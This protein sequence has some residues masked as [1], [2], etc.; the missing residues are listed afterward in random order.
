MSQFLS[1]AIDGVPFG[2]VYALMAIG[3]VLTYQTSGV[4]N[5][6]FGAQAY[7]AALVFYEGVATGWPKWLAF[8]VAVLIVSPGLGVAMDRLLFRHIRT[9]PVLVKL[10][11]ALGMLVAIP[12]VIQLCFGNGAYPNPPDVLLSPTTVYFHLAGDPINGTQLSTVVVTAMAVLL[13]ALMFHFTQVGLR[14]RAMAESPR[15]VQLTGVNAERMGGVTWALSSTLAGLAGVL[16]AP[17]LGVVQSIDFTDLLVAGMAA[18][19]VGSLTSLPLTF[20][21]GIGLGLAE[22]ILGG[23]LPS[24]S[25]LSSGLTFAFPFI[26]LLVLLLFV[27]GL[28][29]RWDSGSDPL[30]G[31]DPPPP[32][33]ASALR[34][35]GLE[36]FMYWGLRVLI[37]VFFL[38]V[39]TWVP[40]SWVFVFIQGLAFSIIFLSITL[41]TGM[42]GQISLCQMAFAGA[43]AFTAGQLAMHLNVSLLA[44]I[45]IGG[46]VAAVLGALV[47]LPAL[48][49]GGLALAIATL[50]FG[51]LADNIG[52]QYSWSGNGQTGVALPRPQLADISF[53][54]DRAFFVLT[55]IVLVIAATAVWLVRR[56]TTGRY[57]AAMRGSELAAASIGI[58]VNRWR[59]VVF[60]LS[61]GLAGVGGA[62]YGS[63]ESTVS[64]ADFNTF[65]SLVFIVVVV[66]TGVHTIEGA[67]QAG[68]AYVIIGEL[69][70]YLPSARWKNLLL[71]LFGLGAITYALH[72]EGIVELEKRVWIERFNRLR[73]GSRRDGSGPAGDMPGRGKAGGPG[74]SRRS[75]GKGSADPTVVGGAL[76]SPSG[77]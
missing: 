57:L 41:L 19:A 16:L 60:A 59:V 1:F 27:P 20:G 52:F 50:A 48:R 32:P 12:A 45:V 14:M 56:G 9:A 65:L 17:P 36:R 8:V 61:A 62:I 24:G 73:A 58:D 72:P 39:L 22:E 23:Y 31:I 5:L 4:F 26:A 42:S 21:G 46:V 35:K 13:L 7:A 29:R 55:L 68:M 10:V 6:A 74:G 70:G 75:G 54:S 67:I 15:M 3:L 77:A 30:A 28:R 40:D 53:Q 63:A 11:S 2:C 38:S 66:T 49:L 44:G 69:L 18:A 43:G 33:L 64:P 37:A 34:A 47:A 25:V 71:I 76:G 51:F